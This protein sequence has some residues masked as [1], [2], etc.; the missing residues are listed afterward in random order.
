ML[1]VPQKS[2]SSTPLCLLKNTLY[3]EAYSLADRKV[4]PVRLINSFLNGFYNVCNEHLE[5]MIEHSE[6][7]KM[8]TG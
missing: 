4:Y 3:C 8:V 5:D 2:S 1:D 6:E 7:S